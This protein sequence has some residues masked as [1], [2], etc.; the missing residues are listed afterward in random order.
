MPGRTVGTLLE[1]RRTAIAG[2]I[3]PLPRLLPLTV[4]VRGVRPEAQ[5][6]HFESV[7]DRTLAPQL[8]GV[9]ALNAALESGGTGVNQTARWRMSLR[10]PGRPPLVLTDR[11]A[12]DGLLNDLLT[13]VISP[14]AFLFN[15][16]YERLHLDSVQVEVEFAPGR[17]LRTLRVAR[18]DR[19]VVKPGGEVVVRVELE[20]YRG[21]S[22]V[23]EIRLPVPAEIG[24][25]DAVVWVGGGPELSRFEAQRLPGRY[26]VGSL[27]EA[28]RRM[29][30]ARTSDGIYA[31]LVVPAAEV[32]SGG[33]D[34]PELP[35]SAQ[36]VMAAPP[37]R[38]E[39]SRAGRVALLSEREDRVGG[40]VRGE[41]QLPLRVDDDAP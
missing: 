3:G 41:T 30:A 7:E 22:E 9:A 39:V 5:R 16:P 15:N 37:L 28:W 18:L 24:E 17:D 14:L 32:S 1:D 21:G 13:Q 2:R 40:V 29:A 19:P 8:V 12:G 35:A 31:V 33:W 10:A 25:G 11:V 26:R 23:R 34:F 38:G 27:D 6:F 20:R 36:A 4:E